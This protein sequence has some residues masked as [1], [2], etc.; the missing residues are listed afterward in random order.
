MA[1]AVSPDCTF[2]LT[3]SADPIVVRYDL[4]VSLFSV[5]TTSSSFSNKLVLK[6]QSGGENRFKKFRVKQPGNASAAIKADG[7]VCAIGGWDGK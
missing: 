6:L 4:F 1:M 2:A 3:T 5:I 7:R